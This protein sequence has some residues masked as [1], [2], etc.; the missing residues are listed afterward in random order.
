MSTTIDTGWFQGLIKDKGFSQ[1]GL[2][3]LIDIDHAALSLMLNGKR[4]M[5]VGEAGTLAQF[6][7]VPVG[8][9]LARAGVTVQAGE[10]SIPV[11]GVVAAGGTLNQSDSTKNV[12]APQDM[13]E[14]ATA[15]RVNSPGAPHHGWVLFYYPARDVQPDAVGRLS[16]VSLA[17]GRIMTGFLARGFDEG[18]YTVTPLSGAAVEDVRLVSAAPV[19]WIR[20]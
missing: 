14:G 5:S 18:T 6:L 4:K 20:T 12:A 3:K 9:V 19:R 8:E 1:R 15:I 17:D 10:R 7:G 13:R 16:V 11:R 2:A